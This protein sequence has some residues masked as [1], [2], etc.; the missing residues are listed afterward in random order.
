MF[1]LAPYESLLFILFNFFT[2]QRSRNLR[3]GIN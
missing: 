2:L 3:V 1:V